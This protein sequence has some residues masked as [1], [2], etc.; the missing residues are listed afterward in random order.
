MRAKR[1]GGDEMRA[2][3]NVSM[4]PWQTRNGAGAA[5]CKRCVFSG[6]KI[7]VCMILATKDLGHN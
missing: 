1:Q 5:I 2:W 7:N 6:G 3:E 4:I